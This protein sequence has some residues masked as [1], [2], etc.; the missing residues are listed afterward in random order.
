M[1]NKTVK[2]MIAS[3]GDVLQE[4]QAV[5][6][7]IKNINYWAV[8]AN[9]RF[10]TIDWENN[11]YPT[12]S[13]YPQNAINL[14]IGDSYDILIGIFWSKIGTPTPKYSSGSIEEIEN[15]LRKSQKNKNINVML[16]FKTDEI[17]SNSLDTNQIE[18]LGNYKKILSKK[19]VYYWEFKTA[20]DFKN[21][22]SQHLALLVQDKYWSKDKGYSELITEI[23][24]EPI[25]SAI[26]NF[27][28]ALTM[29]KEI[30]E[31]ISLLTIYHQKEAN[32]V[33]EENDK[34]FVLLELPTSQETFN[35][36]RKVIDK[37]TLRIT[38]QNN[39]LKG[40]ISDFKSSFLKMF[41]AYSSATLMNKDLN[42]KTRKKLLISILSLVELT[43]GY[44]KIKSEVDKGID[45]HREELK[46]NKFPA[47]NRALKQYL[48][49]KEM[50]SDM[51]AESIYMIK[52][53]DKV[54]KQIILKNST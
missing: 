14:Q 24:N 5:R 17:P 19:G 6:D 52:E 35:E 18:K 25:K 13:N 21:Y 22:L 37:S 41:N 16:Y 26:E 42:K 50:Y 31:I 9:I 32:Q 33:N 23:R 46:D 36:I 8:F 20:N 2:I 4:R 40:E 7:V 15:A 12:N 38:E 3:P 39:F 27:D 48:K 30:H 53:L 28:E 34:I 11:T 29:R 43:T 10:E 1:D 54:A 44:E 51:Y 45:I 47:Y 49:T